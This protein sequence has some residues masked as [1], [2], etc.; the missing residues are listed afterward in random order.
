MYKKFFTSLIFVLLLF[1]YG[2]RP[3]GLTGLV[4]CSGTLTLEGTPLND[5][6]VTFIPNQETNDSEQRNAFAKTDSAG[7]FTM[8]T[9]KENDG[10]YPGKYWIIVTKYEQSGQFVKT[11]EVN[12]ETGKD[13]LFEPAINRLPARY[14]NYL[15]SKLEVTVPV[16]GNKKFMLE[17]SK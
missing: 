13:I 1:L 14:E 4:P 5:A 9:L 11:G 3:S 6:S 17:L 7:H 12:S 15:E 16:S 2:C 8:T 10:V